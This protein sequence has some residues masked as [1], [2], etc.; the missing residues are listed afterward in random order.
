MNSIAHTAAIIRTINHKHRS[1]SH[2]FVRPSQGWDLGLLMHETDSLPLRH[3]PVKTGYVITYPNCE[4]IMLRN[5]ET[6]VYTCFYYKF[7]SSSQL[8]FIIE[9]LL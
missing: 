2:Y 1:R 6:S 5:Q 7:T 9:S 3:Y 4:R 8:Y